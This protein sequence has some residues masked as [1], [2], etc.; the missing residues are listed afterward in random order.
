M[1]QNPNWQPP[2]QP[3]QSPQGSQGPTV[4]QVPPGYGAA[5]GAAPPAYGPPAP[6][7]PPQ[8]P[9]QFQSPQP[10]Q[11]PPQAPP[12]YG[13]PP[14]W[15]AQR[16]PAQPAP[17]GFGQPPV[18]ASTFRDF[19]TAPSSA[20]GNFL[21]YKSKDEA[22]IHEITVLKVIYKKSDDPAK[23]GA[24]LFIVEV[25]IVSSN[26]HAPGETRSW[27][28][29]MNHQPAKGNVKDFMFALLQSMG[30]TSDQVSQMVV[31]VGQSG[32]TRFAEMCGWIVGPDNPAGRVMPRM[33]AECKHILTKIGGDFTKVTWSP[34]APG[35]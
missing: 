10:P 6:Y 31:E 2:Y 22:G 29:N 3:Q 9:P 8:A 14:S 20:G 7:A 33:R 23:A 17:L 30:Y 15:Q 1:T 34:R 4:T 28:C 25:S 12:G 21:N 24:W 16:P 5:P 11:A 18:G 19:G 35:V 32:E 13:P 27:T 26:V